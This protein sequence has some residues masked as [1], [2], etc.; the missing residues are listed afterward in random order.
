MGFSWRRGRRRRGEHSA[1]RT[2]QAT[3]YLSEWRTGVEGIIS[4]VA[5]SS[6]FASRLR[7]LGVVPGQ[8]IRVLRA[9]CPL[10]VQVGEGRFCLRKR[11]AATIRV[12]PVPP[13]PPTAHLDPSRA[14]AA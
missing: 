2:P 13:L 4:E 14:A 8:R 6:R 1:N 3:D 7:E 12:R 11:D 9:E 5:G 10:I